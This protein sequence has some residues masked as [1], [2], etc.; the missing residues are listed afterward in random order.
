METRKS[1]SK[2]IF[3]AIK[4]VEQMALS[5]RICV[6]YTCIGYDRLTNQG[7]YCIDFKAHAAIGLRSPVKYPVGLIVD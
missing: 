1:R 3:E 7:K 6:S 4:C 5:L 2:I